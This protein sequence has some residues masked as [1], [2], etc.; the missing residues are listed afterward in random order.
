[1]E[2]KNEVYHMSK[3]IGIAF[4]IIG[5]GIYRSL[6]ETTLL[7]SAIVGAVSAGVGGAIGTIYDKYLGKYD[8][9]VIYFIDNILWLVV[10]CIPGSIAGFI[11]SSFF[12]ETINSTIQTIVIISIMLLI[13][14]PLTYRKLRSKQRNRVW[15]I[16]EESKDII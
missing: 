8:F 12:G 13:S 7:G 14:L 4:L 16:E 10:F 6:Y 5:V 3:W 11:V 1:M 15:Q 2:L 9:N